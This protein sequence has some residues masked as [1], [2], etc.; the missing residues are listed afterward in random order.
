MRVFQRIVPILFLVSQVAGAAT[1][2]GAGSDLTTG[3][4][5]RN[6]GV[7]KPLDADGNN[8]YGS[9]GYVLITSPGGP[10]VSLPSY[11]LSVGNLG[12]EFY[13]GQLA[14]YTLVDNPTAAGT[15]R[16]GVWYQN[17]GNGVEDNILLFTLSQNA[18]FRLGVLVDTSGQV[19]VSPS[20]LRLR[21]TVGGS[22][23]S[24]LIASNLG[25][26]LSGDWYFFDVSG[27]TG[28]QFIL[29][30][31]NWYAGGAAQFSN[32]VAGLTFDSV[33]EPATVGLI[34]L[35]LAGLLLKRQRQA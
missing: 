9:D 2:V 10:L 4:A 15:I 6:S 3:A 17:S 16:T 23:N 24:G 33:P 14:A 12:L 31:V 27:L 19:D 18:S 7:A 32:G 1:I 25:A 30:G 34:G 11:V 35:A 13:A 21:Q 8:I 5:W 29:S 20:S 26:N 22:A 28:D